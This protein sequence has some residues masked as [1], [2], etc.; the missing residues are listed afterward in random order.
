MN[1]SRAFFDYTRTLPIEDRPTYRGCFNQPITPSLRVNQTRRMVTLGYIFSHVWTWPPESGKP[2]TVFTW[3]APFH[4]TIITE[5]IH[6]FRPES[7]WT[8][9]W[10]PPGPERQVYRPDAPLTTISS[11]SSESSEEEPG[12]PSPPPDYD[13]IQESNVEDRDLEYGFEIV[14]LAENAPEVDEK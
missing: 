11:S 7:A 6:F 9:Y 8:Q 10:Y 12:T 1:Y 14:S 4:G 5:P 2:P 13:Y 3:I